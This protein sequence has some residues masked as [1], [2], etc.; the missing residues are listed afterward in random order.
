MAIVRP[1]WSVRHESLQN[2][3]ARCVPELRVPHTQPAKLESS[4]SKDV[5]GCSHVLQFLLTQYRQIVLQS[6]RCL[7]L[8][9]SQSPGFQTGL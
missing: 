9:L 8:F 2:T 3:T 1:I 4:A 6:L 7:L 5:Y